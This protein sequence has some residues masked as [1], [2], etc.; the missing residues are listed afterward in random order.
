MKILIQFPDGLKSKAIE[1]ASKYEKEGHE[2]YF[3]ASS[4]FGACDL[5]LEEA[6]AI[7]ANKIIH[8]G[9]SKFIKKSLPIQVEYVEFH[10]NFDHTK[11]KAHL[12]K[13]KD[14]HFLAIG[15]TI[16]FVKKLNN[17]KELFEEQ[18]KKV[19]I[20]KGLF[21]TYPGQVLGCDAGAIQSVISDVDA[22]LFIGDGLFHPLAINVKKPVYVYNPYSDKLEQ[23]NHK[24]EKL[25]KKRKG[26]LASAI[27]SNSVGILVSTKPGQF[28]LSLA[29]RMKIQLE[30]KGKRAKILIAN[31]FSPMNLNNF[32]HFDCYITTACPRLSDDSELFEKPILDKE[33]F[34][35]L[36][37]LLD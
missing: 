4:C 25:R 12:N 16:Q 29:K 9:H 36:I 22:V 33:L 10:I 1:Y 23:I 32:Q 19:I 14:Y 13:L 20:G 18:G 3:S 37:H 31:M 2:V 7:K 17:I 11:L 34:F 27:Y 6:K 24:I 15:T 30:E 28:N 21:T 35:E 5:A 8:F 26:I